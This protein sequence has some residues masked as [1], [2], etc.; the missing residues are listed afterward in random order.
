LILKIIRHDSKAVW[1]KK[2]Q[3]RKSTLKALSAVPGVSARWFN[4]LA[5]TDSFNNIGLVSQ[6]HSRGSLVAEALGLG[7]WMAFP[8][9][10]LR[11]IAELASEMAEPASIQPYSISA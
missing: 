9:T 6:T 2:R 5:P 10:G 11:G 8:K 1:L 4:P 3:Y 7:A